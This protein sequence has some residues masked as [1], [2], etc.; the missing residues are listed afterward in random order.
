M[1]ILRRLLVPPALLVLAVLVQ[2]TIV[3]RLPLPGDA[4]PDLVLLVVVALAVTSGP[5]PGMLAGFAGGLALDVAPPVSNLAGETALVFCAAGYACGVLA[6]QMS[7]SGANGLPSRG[8]PG[9]TGRDPGK[10]SGSGVRN[11][12]LPVLMS[13]PVM[14][15]GV[16]IAEALR[17][18]L[19]LTLSDP[20]MTGPAI[21]HVLPAAIVYDVLFCPLAL[22]LVTVAMGAPEPQSA[23]LGASEPARPAPGRAVVRD[24]AAGAVVGGKHAPVPRL[25]F[26]GA[27]QAPLRAP[28]SPP[29]RL[30]LAG[31][32]SSVSRANPSATPRRSSLPAGH[33]VRVHFDSASRDGVI[34]GGALRGSGLRGSGAAGSGA[35]GSR[36]RGSALRGS[37]LRGTGPG[38]W[39]GAGGFG[40]GFSGALG[41]SLFA[42]AGSR[43]PGRNWLRAS[44]NHPL[45]GPAR[46]TAGGSG[47]RLLAGR[48]DGAARSPGKGWLQPGKP[49]GQGS[50][51]RRPASPGSGWIRSRRAVAQGRYSRSSSWGL[52]AAASPGKGW[53][54]PA[55]P[56][57]PAVRRTPGRGWLRRK[58]ARVRWQGTEP[59]RGWLGQGWPRRRTGLG[60][61]GL[62]GSRLSGSGLRGSGMGRKTLGP[63]RIRIGGRR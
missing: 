7:S 50:A 13:L 15:A 57:P 63:G 9:G 12:G 30:R 35:Q 48:P 11:T 23:M 27:R 51:V 38:A 46:A 17:A 6:N 2:V 45:A 28:V 34:G 56:V 55:K 8:V 3:N 52:P 22:W 24:A 21:T 26:G 41:P 44:R 29:P 59:G 39:G 1:W 62:R 54:R 53:I 42:G 5:L 61:S 49:A 16:A 19:G 43:G 33:P 4:T 40:G 60:G 36:L 25:T 20:R 10:R 18:G 37:S 14:A 31:S 47:I 32:S 58:P